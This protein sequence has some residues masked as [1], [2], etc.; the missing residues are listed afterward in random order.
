M[1]T[2]EKK[3]K[4]ALERAKGV[5]E[6]N[7]LM[8]YLK[9]GIEYIFPELK[10]SE[11]ERIRKI[12]Y[13]WIYTQPSEFFEGGF[14]KEEMLTW[15]EKQGEQ[16]LTLPKWKYKKDNTPLLRD[17][18]ILN[19]YGCVAKS[20]SG[21]LVSDVWVMDYD[22]L[23]KLPKEDFEE[24][25]EQKPAWSE[26][27]DAHIM[28]IDLAVNRCLGKWHCCGETCPISEH[29]PWLKSLKDRVQPQPKQE[30]SEEE[31]EICAREAEDNNCIIL[32][33]HIRQLKSL[34]H[35][36][37]WKPSDEQMRTLE[38]YM[39]TLVCTK[40]KEILFGLYSDLKEL[41]GE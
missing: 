24:Q 40:Y 22:E 35:Q 37:T 17:S 20:P 39:H 31:I 3:Y 36:S 10:E 28:A 2:Y 33:K 25:N 16:K 13:G 6:Q 11:G 14:S 12:I 32:A 27:D 38:H 23:A 9:K 41:R 1:D 21:A 29:N 34:R 4:E 5:I 8:E 19:K 18:I 15:L 7:P 26:E 30:C